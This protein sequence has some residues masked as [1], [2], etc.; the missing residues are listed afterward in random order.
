M[1]DGAGGAG[2]SAGQVTVVSVAFAFGTKIE[3]VLA[4]FQLHANQRFVVIIGKNLEQALSTSFDTF[5]I[6]ATNA[7]TG[8]DG[9]KIFATIIRVS[10]TGFH[11]STGK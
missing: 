4:E 5:M 7:K 10:I 11:E 3:Q 8:I 2:F 6:R 9:D 1:F